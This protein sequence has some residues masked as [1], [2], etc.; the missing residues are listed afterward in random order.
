M[1]FEFIPWIH[2]E[3]GFWW[4]IGVMALIFVALIVFFSYKRYLTRTGR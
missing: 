1:N 4:A 2:K 3:D